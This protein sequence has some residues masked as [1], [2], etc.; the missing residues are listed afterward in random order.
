VHQL[1]I[2]VLKARVKFWYK[3]YYYSGT[4]ILH[5]CRDHL[6]LNL[7][8]RKVENGENENDAI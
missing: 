7:K 1:E 5:F 4:R 2:K 6:E 3:H 8:L